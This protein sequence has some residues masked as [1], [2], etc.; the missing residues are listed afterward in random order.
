MEYHVEGWV[1]FLVAVEVH[2]ESQESAKKLVEQRVRD[3]YYLD[4]LGTDHY[5]ESVEI[6][7]YADEM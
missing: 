5:P 3:F 4:S 2:A 1:K 6:E 7:L